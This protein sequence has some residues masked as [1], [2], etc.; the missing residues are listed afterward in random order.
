M[1]PSAAFCKG[2][3]KVLASV[4]VCV[5]AA[6]P[7]RATTPESYVVRA[8]IARDAGVVTGEVAVTVRL[9]PS[10]DAIR[11]WL[12]GDR[13]A[14]APAA[15]DERSARW[16]YP[17][18]ID[19][20]ALRVRG[21]RVDGAPARTR[22]VSFP[23]GSARARDAAGSDLEVLVAPRPSARTVRVTFAF[24]LRVPDRYGRLGRA[25][26]MLSLA[27][28]WYP[29][30]VGG[31]DA[32]DHDAAHDVEVRLDDGALWLG[33][34]RF[35][36]TGRVE[37][38]AP[39]VPAGA[40]SALHDARV[41][42]EGVQV[43]L[44]SPSRLYV[45]PPASVRGEEGMIDLG[46]V[47]VIGLVRAEAREAIRT[48]R[49]FG[50]PVPARVELVEIP[51]RTELVAN[52]PGV[53]LFSDRLFQ[54][55]PLD[56]TLDFHRQVLRRALL[57]HLAAPLARVDAPADRGWATDLRAVVLSD[58]DAARRR[59]NGQTPQ[60]LLGVLSFHP[61]VDQLLYAPQIAFEDAYFAAIEERDPFRDD[62]VRARRPLSRGRRVLE[63]A[64]D[65]LDERAL[66]RFVAMLVNARRP[67]R[68]ALARAAPER[69][70]RL[71]GWLA[72]T[73]EPVNYRLGERRS[74]PAEAGFRHV[75]TLH[76]DGADRAEPV[77]VRVE[78]DRGHTRR[79]VWDA[80][81][82][83]G[84]VSVEMPGRLGGVTLDPRHRLPQ[85]PAL[86]DGHPRI[87]DATDHPWR[88][89]I[90]NGF[91]FNVFV[92]EADFVGLVDFVLRRRYDLEH[93][94]GLRAERTRAFTGGTLR[95][96]HGFGDKVHTN[97]RLA[98]LAASVSFSRL[99]EF[100]GDA[101]LGGWRTQVEL[102]TSVNSVAFALDPN[103]GFWGAASVT[104]GL[105]V[106]DDGTLGYTFRGGA[107]GG[108]AIPLSLLNT[109]VLVAG[110]GFTFGDA[111]ASELQS[112]GGDSRLRGF[113]SGELLGRG[114]VY[115]VVEHRFR[116]F[117]DLAINLA[118]LIWVREIQLA[119]FAGAGV[120]FDRTDAATGRRDDA[121]GG[122]DV[123]G[124]V[125]VHYEYGGVQPG[126]ISIDVGLPL[127]RLLAP[128]AGDRP[129]N[130]I[131]FYIG[132]DQFF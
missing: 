61:A 104:G 120:V 16:I 76:R 45:Q 47:D 31:D 99:H 114:V 113:E 21:V 91:V 33:E 51:S 112:L 38:V 73:G 25:R 123:G 115:G 27:A 5:L 15:M 60:D 49:A 13:L 41:E 53:V 64:R 32:F 23:V 50:L 101:D 109:L 55:I 79:A 83:V 42:V 93:G 18:E 57:S 72:A 71:E 97:R 77:E 66:A 108:V 96:E 20:G 119:L 103:E 52:A 17:G 84:E 44:R 122:A 125:R 121:V 9:D 87:D 28:P 19:R 89:P 29:L 95:Y 65:A 36:R 39:Y 116:A 86:A 74:E 12:Y 46:R 105:A 82:A 128:Q 34:R 124:G 92:T 78:D 3:A 24:E 118:H 22:R 54:I 14:V 69:A 106:R 100:F 35:G 68:A 70:E 63:A 10:E 40:A 56:Q 75:V 4:A 90:L 48:A 80:P 88:L 126:V 11:L 81:G 132:F 107:R 37:R 26:G 98:R 2:L 129:R 102:L 1:I 110:G 130:P 94:F 7:A 58:L 62:P 6:A 43:V 8:T 67:A 131:G 59:R 117:R 85:S 127:T 111:L 30:V